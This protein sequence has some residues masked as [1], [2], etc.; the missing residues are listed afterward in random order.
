MELHSLVRSKWLKDKLRRRGRGD[1]SGRGNYSGKGCKGQKA[2]S[3]FT[4]RP[5]FEGGQTSIVQ[6]MPKHRGFKRYYKLVTPRQTVNL[7]LLQKDGRITSSVN[8]D[9]LLQWGYVSSLDQPV[10]ILGRGDLEKA[11]AFEGI[12]DYS[13][14]AREK[15][16]KAW[17]SIK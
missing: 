4:M 11:L 8:K 10:K 5:Y 14:S 7:G 12:E 2:R 6:R 16:E 9:L 13:A 15:I 3:G 1:A 17:G